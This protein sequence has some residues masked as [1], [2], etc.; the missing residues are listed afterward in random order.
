MMYCK[1]YRHKNG[2]P[3][4]FRHSC[5]VYHTFNRISLTVTYERSRERERE[6]E[7]EREKSESEKS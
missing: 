6:R 1:I 4:N 7:Q 2:T 3:V 5:Q